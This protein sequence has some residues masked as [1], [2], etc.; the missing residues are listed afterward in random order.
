[1]NHKP[2]RTYFAYGSNM[3]PDQMDFRCPGALAI[4]TA[5]LKNYRFIINNREVASVIPDD[6]DDVPDVG[7]CVIGILWSIS[8][9]HER[10]LDQCEGI[11]SNFYYRDFVHVETEDSGKIEALIYIASDSAEGTPREGYLEKILAGAEHFNLPTDYI[12]KL[13]SWGEESR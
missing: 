9:D 8:E 1:M 3:N 13:R 10:T 7:N 11:D 5:T 12:E 6:G 4:G 2:D